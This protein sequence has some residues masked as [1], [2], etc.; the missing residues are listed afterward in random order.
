MKRIQENPRERERAAVPSGQKAELREI[1]L[2]ANFE[3]ILA[4]IRRP[5]SRSGPQ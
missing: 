5:L 3:M 4:F 2:S 1:R